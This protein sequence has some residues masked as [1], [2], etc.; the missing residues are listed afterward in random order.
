MGSLLTHSEVSNLFMLLFLGFLLCFI[1]GC[2]FLTICRQGRGILCILF[3]SCS[4]RSFCRIGCR[5]WRSLFR[6]HGAL[7]IPLIGIC[8]TFRS[9][10]SVRL[11]LSWTCRIHLFTALSAAACYYFSFISRFNGPLHTI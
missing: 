4:C 6:R 5:L 1:F 11:L 3:S 10:S 7:G 9:S 2:F 8:R